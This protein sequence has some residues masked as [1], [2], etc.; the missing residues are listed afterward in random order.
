MV[1]LPS[2]F[3]EDVELVH[4]E[5]TDFSLVIKGKPF[6]ERYEGLKQYRSMDYHDVMEFAANGDNIQELK[7][8]DIN[9]QQLMEPSLL[10]P[11]FF[12]NGIYQLLV[13]PKN[14]KELTFYHEHPLLRQAVSPMKIGNQHILTGNLQFQNEVG[15]TTFEIRFG[16]EKLLEVTL[17]IFPSKLDYKNDY[18]KLLEEVNDEI[19]NLAYHFIRKTYLG[20]RVKLEGKPS[21]SEFYRL[22]SHH[23]QQFLQAISRLE[24][25]P[26]HKLEKTYKK[27]RG[28]QIR[29]LDS[30]SRN[31]LRKRANLFV[32][33]EK[34][35]KF[36]SKQLMPMKGLRIKKELTYD[37]N[38]NRYVKWMMQRLIHKLTDL[39]NSIRSINKRSPI[40]P[41][42]VKRIEKMLNQLQTKLKQT[43]WKNIGKLDRSVMSL[44][45]EMA[46][47][48][49][50]AFQ[51]YLTVSKGL[52]LQGKVYQM[53][54]KDVATLYE[55]WTFLKLGQ[56]MGR[57]YT[58][59]SQDIVQ[60][61]HEG[62]FVNLEA[63]R[64]AKR[65][66]RHPIT[67]EEI[68][69]TYQKYEGR[70]P[71]IPQKPDT[72]LSIEKKGKDYTFNYIFDAKYRIDYAQRDSYY[73]KRYKT[74]GPMEDDIN[75]MHRYRDSIVASIDGPYERIAFGAYV[76]F[77]WFDEQSYEKHHFYNSIDKVNIGGLPFLPNATALV[78]KF[79]ERLIDKSPEEIQSEGIL[80][81][82]KQEEWTSSFGEAV[83]VGLVSSKKEY[84]EFIKDRYFSIP[85][86]KLKN[87]W[88]KAKYVALYLK[89]GVLP[90]HGVK[91]Y[92]KITELKPGNM[93]MKFKVEIWINLPKI[94]KPVNYGI[95]SYILTTMN[96][97]NT[98]I[99]LP[100]LFMKSEN[101]M[102]IWRMLRR[103]SDRIKLDLD[104]TE[105]NQASQI[106]EYRIKDI[107]VQMKRQEHEVVFVSAQKT[108]VISVDQLERNPSGIFRILVE[109]M[110][111]SSTI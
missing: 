47:G 95:S 11:I 69:L 14:N 38:E 74:P 18:K 102:K 78:E 76:L 77:P 75:T 90:E 86:E 26:H 32:E 94:I 111:A 25:Q 89:K 85:T 44:V 35:I 84:D 1:L 82:G 64:M 96:N 6:H 2:G 8:Y 63:N 55:Y 46:P 72:M 40:D 93:L 98:A 34:G 110:E 66:Y 61:N 31:Y 58:L 43:F 81:R 83:F 107:T 87:G 30:K 19:Y 71:T 49:R 36:E 104:D 15:F 17:E 57:K 68:V 80:P 97:L 100:E 105:L 51:I 39:L 13:I 42:L 22:I 65:V 50:D 101:E 70:L 4:I 29:K 56:I 79:I 9:Q 16:N 103:V 48:Y 10:R 60:V 52:V 7:V 92:G 5:T 37:T 23:F 59:M 54:V 33:V 28:D 20:A 45:L 62:L 67:K 53:S 21:R 108:N 3:R 88:Q 109:M 73:E 27:A 99:E 106:K 12:E 41:D 91:V 24:R